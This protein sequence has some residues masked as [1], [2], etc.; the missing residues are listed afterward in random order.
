MNECIKSIKNIELT[1]QVYNEIIYL[2][3]IFY[4]INIS[5]ITFKDF[6]T[7]VDNLTDTH[8]IYLYY[9]NEYIVGSITLLIEPKLY[10]IKTANIKDLIVSPEYGNYNIKGK[11]LN[12]VIDI[13]IKNKYDKINIECK[14]CLE[15]HYNK[16][17]F[18]K[19]G[20]CMS[21]NL[22]N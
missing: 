16:L 7:I 13:S 10:N 20:I 8:N 11:L 9:I 6:K 3:N 5:D 19:Y 2:Y 12:H 1:Q 15:K 17:R 4:K 21:K 14:E 18:Y 22:S